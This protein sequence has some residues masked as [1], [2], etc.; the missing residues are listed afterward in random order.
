MLLV[1]QFKL[2]AR[3]FNSMPAILVQSLEEKLARF[4]MK[5][6]AVYFWS[7]PAP[8]M[9]YISPN[10]TCR[11][12]WRHVTTRHDKHDISWRNKW[13]LGYTGPT[14]PVTNDRASHIPFS[15][16][17]TWHELYYTPTQKNTHGQNITSFPA[18]KPDVCVLDVDLLHCVKNANLDEVTWL[19][20][21]G[22][23]INYRERQKVYFIQQSLKI[24]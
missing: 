23:D 17:S 2:T 16:I 19:V 11:V 3:A 15:I 20:Q 9:K 12:T 5:V 18:A 21:K 7:G 1:C 24:L 8:F 10:S 14:E 6:T 4:R 13:N 22:R